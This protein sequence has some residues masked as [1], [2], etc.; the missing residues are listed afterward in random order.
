MNGNFNSLYRYKAY[1]LNIHSSFPVAG[2]AVSEFSEPDVRIVEGNVPDS[3]T[4]T[5]NQG[6]FFQSTETEFLLKIDNL[7]HY[8]VCDGNKII[9]QKNSAATW[10]EVSVFI[11][12]IVFGV[13]CHQRKLLPLH[14]S[15]VIYKNK[16]I[17]FLGLSGSGKSTTAAYY[18]QKGGSLV[19]DDVSVIDCTG[20]LPLVLPAYPFIKIWEDSLSKLG[21]KTGVLNPV[22][23]ELK[24]FY[25]PVD[26]F[27]KEPVP[28]NHII[29]LHTH[30][31][32]VFERKEPEGF[33]KFRIFKKHTYLFKGIPHTGLENNHF[34]LVNRLAKEIP[35]TL[36]AR[37][38]GGFMIEELNDQVLQAT[39]I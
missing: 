16:C 11:S 5:R 1:N 31:K 30:N 22:R 29:V 28:V 15:T 32:P 38:A 9:I 13:L 27:Q 37:P 25:F 7:A 6:I 18:I 26:R 19:A 35:L 12:G 36:I 10:Q 21:L 14:A 34:V 20:D 2:F 17:L 33:N 8:Y 24:K 4:N 3:L 39:G 23:N